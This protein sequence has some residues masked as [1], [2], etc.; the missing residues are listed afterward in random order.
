[1]GYGDSRMTVIRY[2]GLLPFNYFERVRGGGTGLFA[3]FEG[4][5]SEGLVVFDGCMA[6]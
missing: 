3:L 1:M 6:N 5:M 4:Y 2:Y